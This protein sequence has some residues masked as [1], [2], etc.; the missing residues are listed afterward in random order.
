MPEFECRLIT[1]RFL[2]ISA[3]DAEQARRFVE[4]VPAET[5][6]DTDDPPVIEIEQVPQANP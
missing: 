2:S 6:H 4:T 1:T 5:W 3:V